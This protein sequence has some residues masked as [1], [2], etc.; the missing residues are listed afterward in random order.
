MLKKKITKFIM[1]LLLI[2]SLTT[3]VSF[4]HSG[5]TDSNGGHKDNKNASGIGSYHY[6][7]GGY[8]AHLHNNGV[9]PYSSNST[10]IDSSSA[11]KVEAKENGY[12]V[13]YKDGA[14]GNQFN[15]SNSLSYS[16]EYKNGYSSGYENGKNE[17]NIKVNSAYD[18][19]FE[20]GYK[21]ESQNNTYIIQAIKNSYSS[22]YKDGLKKY[23]EENKANYIT[24]GEEDAN[25]FK[26]RDFE[27]NVPSELKSEYVSSYNNKTSKLKKDAYNKGYVQALGSEKL[28]SSNYKNDDEINSYKE[29]YDV[30]VISLEEES[31]NA[32]E[33]GF[34]GKEYTVPDELVVAEKVLLSSYNE[35]VEVLQRKKEKQAKV[36]TATIA[37]LLVGGVGGTTL[38]KKKKNSSKNDDLNI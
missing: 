6:H 1:T 13:G 15:D 27:S 35:G 29:G 38:V 18:E 11:E 2:I 34:T 31:N 28:D 8:P 32:Y 20:L 25:N 21:C 24:L 10:L 5:R 37:T 36:T 12:N 22:G 16:S 23:I 9:C 3:Q 19:G 26:M 33:Y 17:L 7:C 14:N 30:G 4:A